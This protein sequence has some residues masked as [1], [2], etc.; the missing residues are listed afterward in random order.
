MEFVL[1]LEFEHWTDKNWDKENDFAN[2][3]VTLPDGRRYGIN[4]WTYQFLQTAI[5]EGLNLQKDIEGC[6]VIPPDLF[7]KELSRQ[8]FQSVI[9]Q[10]LAK[11]NLEE[12]LNASV[13][14]IHFLAPWIEVDDLP[15]NDSAHL[16]LIVQEQF[17][18]NYENLLVLAKHAITQEVL[19][20]LPAKKLAIV[21]LGKRK[22]GNHIIKPALFQSKKEFWEKRLKAD[23]LEFRK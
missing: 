3:G 19:I 18:L 4:V 20:Q 9:K 21:S 17:A 14:G 15:A 11:G 16:Q 12:V 23:I 5:Q 2:I 22:D 6:Y 13:F 7:V 10:L 8:C 1:W